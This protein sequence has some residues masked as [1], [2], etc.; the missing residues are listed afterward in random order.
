MQILISYKVPKQKLFSSAAII[1]KYESFN[2][3]LFRAMKI[4][5]S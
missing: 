4:A 3:A 1:I 2:K 5:E